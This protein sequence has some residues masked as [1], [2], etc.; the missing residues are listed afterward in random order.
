MVDAPDAREGNLLRLRRCATASRQAL[1][2]L[3]LVVL[4]VAGP[5]A[6]R[7]EPLTFAHSTWVG[8]GPAYVARERGY[9]ADEGLTVKLIVMEDVKTRLPALAAGRIDLTTT[10]VDTVLNFHT[11]ERPFRYLFGTDD[12]SGG[13]GI[14]AHR[15]IR[16]IADLRG[17]R[18]AYSEGSVSQFYLSVLLDGA[19]LSLEDVR[20]L[21]MTAGDAGAAFVAGRVDAAVTW[22]PWLTRGRQ[23]AH[24]HLLIDS[25]SSPGLITD[26][27]VTTQERLASRADDLR[28][29]YRAWI[30]AVEWQRDNEAEADAIMARGVGGWLRD[31]EVFKETRAG[32]TYYDAAM[33]AAF[34]GTRSAPGTLTGTIGQALKLGREAGLF[35]IDPAPASLIAFEVVNQ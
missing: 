2:A 29:F 32:I 12:S 11:A 35:D 27:A 34:I 19:G 15:E 8:N 24:G 18:I 31:A 23:A 28:A 30:R 20:G 6:A 13:D 16:T 4:M 10:T 9:F 5:P 22:E 33:N 21:N 26:V 25:S 17:K 7:A 3:G 1:A 14:V